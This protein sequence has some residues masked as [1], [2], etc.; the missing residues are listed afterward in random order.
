MKTIEVFFDTNVLIYA[1]S[2]DANKA[3]RAETLIRSGGIVSVQVLNECAL[4]LRRKFNAPWPKIATA[5]ER[6]RKL[7]TIM[8]LTEDVHVR[9]L[10]VAARHKLHV[11]DG[12]IVGAALIA[13][14]TTLYSED[15]HHGQVIDGLR[16]VNPYK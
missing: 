14:C 7:L 15:M 6:L 1:L 9:G 8:A 16:I 3:A 4:T 10:A 11:S 12:M 5:S 2:G 13:G